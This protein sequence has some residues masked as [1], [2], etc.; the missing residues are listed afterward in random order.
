MKSLKVK[1]FSYSNNLDW[2]IKIG[3]FSE[4]E[5]HFHRFIHSENEKTNLPYENL[6]NYPGSY[7]IRSIILASEKHEQKN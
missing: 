1:T 7:Y 5:F 2:I 4:V 3:H 6:L